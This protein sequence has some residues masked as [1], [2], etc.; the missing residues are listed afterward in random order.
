MK[1]I[2]MEKKLCEK[3]QKSLDAYLDN[4]LLVE[5]NQE[6]LRHLE[7]CP[8]CPEALQLRLRIKARLKQVVNA[9][10]VPNSTKSHTGGDSRSEFDPK[11]AAWPRWSLAAA[12]ALLLSLGGVGTLQLSKFVRSSN[13]NS[14]T[15]QDLTLSEQIGSVMKIGIG[16]HIH[17]VID[18]RYDK[19]MLTPEEMTE[20]MGPDYAG[21]LPLLKTKLPQ[22]FF[23]SV[24]HHCQ[25]SGREFVHMVLK[26]E[27]KAVSVIITEKQG[28][29]FPASPRVSSL[30]AQGGALYQDRLQSLEAVGFETKS[31]LAFVVSSLEHQ[32]NFQIASAVAPTVSAF[33][34]SL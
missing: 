29:S 20:R 8:A 11:Q 3:T 15:A 5:T 26:Q 18:F 27:D 9:E 2:S 22:G 12:A 21:L 7:N 6:V 4:E 33:L 24:G 14:V 25:V 17:C 19:K 31:H 23:I 28:M 32:E 30:E 16:D 34:N 10:V 1:V 13:E